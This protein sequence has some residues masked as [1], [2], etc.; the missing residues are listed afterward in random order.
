MCVPTVVQRRLLA[1]LARASA[2]AGDI[3]GG[4]VKTVINRNR[5]ITCRINI[6]DALRV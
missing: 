6:I 3:V 5:N 4:M 2:F 1:L